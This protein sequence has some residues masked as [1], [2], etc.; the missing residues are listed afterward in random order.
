[1]A[2]VSTSTFAAPTEEDFDFEFSIPSSDAVVAAA[3]TSL[4]PTPTEQK[5][6]V[7][8]LAYEEDFCKC[9]VAAVGKNFVSCHLCGR[10]NFRYLEA[11]RLS[12]D[13]AIAQHF[14]HQ[15]SE[16]TDGKPTCDTYTGRFKKYKNCKNCEKMEIPLIRRFR[17][18]PRYFRDCLEK[19]I[20]EQLIWEN[21]YE[22]DQEE[23]NKTAAEFVHDWMTD[24]VVFVTSRRRCPRRIGRTII[25]EH[26]VKSWFE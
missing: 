14:T 15:Y 3:A 24:D 18:T 23:A 19:K 9:P 13:K 7:E 1:M 20:M 25:N 10:K 16:K 2:D 21:A 12:A 22:P 26:N 11:V 5:A 4:S 17:Q 8:L 6:D